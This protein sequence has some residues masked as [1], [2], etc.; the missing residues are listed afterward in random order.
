MKD[1]SKKKH[2]ILTGESY[3]VIDHAWSP[4]N[5]TSSTSLELKI[6]GTP[7]YLDVTVLPDVTGLPHRDGETVTRQNRVVIAQ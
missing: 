4:F 2:T 1:E 3:S 7:V 5:F 6:E